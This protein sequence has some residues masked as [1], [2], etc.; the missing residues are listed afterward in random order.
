[1]SEKLYV[2]TFHTE[3][4]RGTYSKMTIIKTATSVVELIEGLE[5]YWCKNNPNLRI[6]VDFIFTEN[7]NER[8]SHK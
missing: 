3:D 6:V 2:I 4:F 7:A 8:R 5:K 1:M